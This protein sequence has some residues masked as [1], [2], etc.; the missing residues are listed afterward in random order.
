MEREY[1][2]IMSMEREHGERELSVTETE[3]MEREFEREY[4]E[5]EY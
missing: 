3:S 1:G 2:E 5:S 4:G